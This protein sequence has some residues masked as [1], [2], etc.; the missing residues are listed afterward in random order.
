MGSLW[1]FFGLPDPEGGASPTTRTPAPEPSQG[2]V[3]LSAP[4]EAEEAAPSPTP[5]AAV[6]SLETPS[7]D[8]SNLRAPP[9]GWTGPT[10]PDGEAFHDLGIEITPSTHAQQSASLHFT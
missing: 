3:S 8:V 7:V 2:P 9:L 1:Q 5:P 10:T 6:E 4:G